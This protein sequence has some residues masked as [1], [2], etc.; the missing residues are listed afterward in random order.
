[1]KIKQENIYNNIIIGLTN[2]INKTMRRITAIGNITA[3][4]E[5]KEVGSRKAIN[6]SV[7]INE[8]FVKDGNK[9]E[10][11][12]FYNCTIW[13]EENVKIAQYLTKGTKVFIEG[14]PE[15]EV[16][17]DKQG[18]TKGAIK[19]IVSNIELIGSGSGKPDSN[20]PIVTSPDSIKKE[21]DLPF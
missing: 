17:Q 18:N 2:K 12:T 3:N 21:N 15:V 14:T 4:A 5:V 8:H 9:T 20:S 6:F 13:R 16:Y 19:I 1:L 11:T 7:A 10:K